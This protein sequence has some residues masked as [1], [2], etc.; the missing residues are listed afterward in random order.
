MKKIILLLTLFTFALSSN[1][2]IAAGSV[3]PNFTVTDINGTVHTL[4]TY[5][6]AGK[7]V[8]MDVSATW[9]PPC[10]S[11]H[12]GKA[13]ENIHYAYGPSGSNEVVVL[14]VEGDSTTTLANLNG[15]GA[16][17]QGNWVAGTPYPI[18]D[19]A[20]IFSSYQCTYYPTIYRIT[21]NGLVTEIGQL[22]AAAI[23]TN[24]GTALGTPLNGVLNLVKIESSPVFVSCTSTSAAPKVIIKNFGKAVTG[25]TPIVTVDLKENGIV[26]ASKATSGSFGQFATKDLLFDAITFN[27]SSVYT[28]SVNNINGQPNFN[29]ALSTN[30]IDV[31]FPASTELDII[32]KVSTDNY[33]GEMSWKIKNSTGVVVGSF[34][35]YTAGPGAGGAGGADANTV[36]THNVTLPTANECYTV[37]LIDSYGD[38]WSAGGM[39]VFNGATEVY[40]AFPSFLSLSENKDAL[41]NVS[42]ASNNF[43]KSSVSVYPNPSSGSLRI[44]AD[45]I[46]TVELVDVLGKSVHTSKNVDND[47]VLDLSM[48]NKGLYLVKI[49]GENVSYTEKVILN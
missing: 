49:T 5:L 33:P 2:Q 24:I 6:T 34:G 28:F 43:S 35:P 8:I 29:T 17:T 38:G 39:K 23:R 18:I 48:L 22:S 15:I 44:K 11:Y 42:L 26:I 4:S 46:V 14:F 31:K 47:T 10:W 32:V 16:A 25:V 20:G 3:A 1:A 12:N 41:R 40:S 9:C 30:T 19:N 7:T 45:A 36:K 27:P 37:E 13:L 21:P